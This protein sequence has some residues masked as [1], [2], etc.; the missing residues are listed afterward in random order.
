MGCKSSKAEV[1]PG[2]AHPDMQHF[3]FETQ[4]KRIDDKNF[5]AAFQPFEDKMKAEGLSQEVKRAF[6]AAFYSLASGKG[7]I[8][9]EKDIGTTEDV[10]SFDNIKKS[11]KSKPELLESTVMLKLNGGLGTS[12]GLDKAKSLLTVK[13]NLSFL[14]LVAKQVIAMRE[15]V[16]PV[17]F[18]LMNSFSTSK[19]TKTALAKYETALFGDYSKIE[20]VQ[21]KV[22]K[23]DYSTMKPVSWPKKPQ[24]EWCPPGHGDLYTVL[25]GSGTL[26]RLLKEGK[27]VLFVSNSDNL[28]ATLDMDLLTYFVDSG[29][30]F[31][32]EVAERTENDKKGGHLAVRTADGRHIL[33][34]WAQCTGKDK[35]QFQD[36]TKHKY[37]N[38]NNLWIRLDKLKEEIDKNGGFVS[39][40][41]I[42]NCGTVDPQDAGSTE[43]LQLETAMGA[44]IE[45]FE[46][47]GVV[48]V[49]RSRFVPVKKCVDLLLLRSD[50][51]ELTDE[52]TLKLAAGVTSAPVVNLD[53]KHF[54]LVSQLEL[55]LADTNGQAPSLKSCERLGVTG[56]VTFAPGTSFVGKVE[57]VNASGA[58]KLL[59]GKEYKD[60]TVNL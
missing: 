44:A 29:K 37:F 11:L 57:I 51:Y 48:Q 41:S 30:P 50:V 47:A 40:P 24:L 46:G 43:V 52:C 22:P 38:T 56:P 14:D 19:D 39:L 2:H 17:D 35:S 3:F 42:E 5:L 36:V 28:G 34:E 1:V 32:M 15:K 54:K 26:D 4:E 25:A 49:P 21:N 27:K 6:R 20:V 10:P 13:D 53:D 33:R 18:M 58:P 59:P 8:I 12:M 16:G 31:L 55:A 23:I 9:S 7:G 45:A 60:E